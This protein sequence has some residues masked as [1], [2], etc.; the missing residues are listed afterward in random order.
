MFDNKIHKLISQKITNNNQGDLP[1]LMYKIRFNGLVK[2]AE[3]GQEKGNGYVQFERLI[4]L[5]LEKDENMKIKMLACTDI[6]EA[7]KFICDG[8][9][10]LDYRNV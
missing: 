9:P 8:C 10:G 3:L 5:A 7:I 1:S 2:N 6:F 4:Y